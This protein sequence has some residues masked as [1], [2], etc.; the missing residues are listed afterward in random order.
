MVSLASVQQE[1]QKENRVCPLPPKWAE[2]YEIFPKSK[3]FTE[4]L[5]SPLILAGWV[6]ST[7]A[8]KQSR[9]QEH[10]EW[11]DENGYLQKIAEFLSG[12]KE[13]DWHHFR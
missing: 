7:D 4:R 8:E 1:A 3:R 6:G 10:I 9:L 11:A 13:D 12:L 5:P 2:M